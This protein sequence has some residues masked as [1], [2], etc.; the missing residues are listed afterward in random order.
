MRCCS[1]FRWIENIR[2]SVSKLARKLDHS[3]C[4]APVLA[5]PGG[6]AV[7][8]FP[9]VLAQG[10]FDVSE[11]AAVDLVGPGLVE[12][13]DEVQ[14]CFFQHAAGSQVHGH[15][16]GDDPP[17][18]EFV[19]PIRT[20]AR[21]PSVAWPFPQAGLRSRN[22]STISPAGPPWRGWKR[23]HPRKAPVDFSSAAQQPYPPGSGTRP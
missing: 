13:P 1:H 15:G 10:V 8:L 20:R 3:M 11:L 12:D 5:L 17:G 4:S 21:D 22:P 6:E 18:A 14:A 16:L 19:K 2:R 23:N 7:F 9:F